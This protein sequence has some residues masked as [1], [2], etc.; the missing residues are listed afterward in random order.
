MTPK[1]IR[2]GV[3]GE[4]NQRRMWRTLLSLYRIQLEKVVERDWLFFCVHKVNLDVD[5]KLSPSGLCHFVRRL[6]A[7]TVGLVE[8]LV[9]LENNLYDLSS[10]K[11]TCVLMNVLL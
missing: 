11:C 10:R 5:F 9:Q 7:C 4:V 6:G 1:I 3:H 2:A 8:R